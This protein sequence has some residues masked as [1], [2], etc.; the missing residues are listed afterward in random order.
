MTALV[1]EKPGASA[2]SASIAATNA[3]EATERQELQ[4]LQRTQTRQQHDQNSIF[5]S[6]CREDNGTTGTALF[7]K[8]GEK[9]KARQEQEFLETTRAAR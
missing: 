4:L 6:K 9:T 3:D 5:C 1:L 7:A 2:R 8:N